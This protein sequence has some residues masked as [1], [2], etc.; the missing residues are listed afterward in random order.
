MERG[1]VLATGRARE[2]AAAVGGRRFL[3]D[4]TAAGSAMLR[5]LAEQG[6]VD[7]VTA[8]EGVLE[9]WERLA[10]SVPGNE[11]AHAGAQLVEA[12]VG[13]GHPVA[14]C[15][16]EPTSLADLISAVVRGAAH[17]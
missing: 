2:L 10:I 16:V 3:I 14:G 13:A 5:T 15:S 17:G 12:L 1:R 7:S 6:R 4:T 8:L 9:G 11:A